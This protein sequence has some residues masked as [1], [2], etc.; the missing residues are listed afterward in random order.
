MF[1]I[2][3]WTRNDVKRLLLLPININVMDA[4][5]KFSF[6][7]E[8]IA[9]TRFFSEEKTDMSFVEFVDAERIARFN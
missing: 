1:S 2:N 4:L 6:A 9:Y 5:Q 8:C 7:H 3:A